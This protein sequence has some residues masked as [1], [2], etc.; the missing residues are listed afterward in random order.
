MRCPKC[1]ASNAE[2]RRFCR[3][4]GLPLGDRCPTC[5]FVNQPGDLYCGGCGKEIAPLVPSGIAGA[6]SDTP[7]A[8]WRPAEAERRQITV[9][10]CDLVGSTALSEQLDPEEMRDL[11][12]A[13]REACSAVVDRYEGWIAQFRG[14]GILIYFG[15]PEA[16]ED[17][18]ARAVRAA[19]EIVPAVRGVHN[20]WYAEGDLDLNVR[21][22]IDTG[23]VVIG[24]L[25]SGAVDEY[26]AAVG[27]S[28][29]VASRVQGYA[30]PGA[31]LITGNTMRLVEGLFIADD[32]G[33]HALRGVNEPVHLYRVRGVSE[34][35]TRFEAASSLTA[36]VNREPELALGLDCWAR[37]RAG[38]GQ[39]L[40]VSGE[41][42][43]GKSRLIQVLQEQIA[44]QPHRWVRCQCSP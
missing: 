43:I 44:D 36:F 31:V 14:D 27:D 24:D 33:R 12:K 21:I 30:E 25:P 1:Q 23:L 13:Y 26:M 39:V 2:G 16:H 34:S 40:L 3:G 11:F 17:D 15:Y 22:G 8:V 29:N 28:P 6:A 7:R 20:R 5:D 4:C 32:L 41:A 35:I 38:D 42:G 10:F 37:A 9:M 18:A 19:L